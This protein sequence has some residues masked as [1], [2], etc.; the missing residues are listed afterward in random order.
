MSAATPNHTL[1]AIYNNAIGV[2]VGAVMTSKEWKALVLDMG[3]WFSWWG[4]MVHMSAKSIGGG[5]YEIKGR[6]E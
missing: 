5:V 4:N 6:I 2:G 1:Q 3:S